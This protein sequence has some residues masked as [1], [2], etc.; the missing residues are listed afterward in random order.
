[1][2]YEIKFSDPAKPNSIVIEDGVINDQST[3]LNL[4]GKNAPS[5]GKGIAEN[6]VHSLENFASSAPPSNPIEGQLWFDTSNP[7]SKKLRINDGGVSG[8]RW[9]PINGVFQQSSQPTNVTVGDI[10]VDTNGNQLWIY[11]GISFTLVGPSYSSATLTGGY[12]T[13]INDRDGNSHNVIINYVNGEAIEVI[14][15]ETF[16][17]NDPAIDVNNFANGIYPGINVSTANKIS[18]VI[19]SAQNLQISGA[20]VAASQFLRKDVDQSMSARLNILADDSAL[21]IGVDPTIIVQRKSQYNANFVNTYPNEGVFTFD[22]INGGITKTIMYMS[23]ATNRVGINT[24]SPQ[25]ELD[26]TGSLR[27]SG[28]GTVSTLYVSSNATSALRVTGG[29]SIGGTVSISSATTISGLLTTNGIVPNGTYDIGAVGHA[30]NRVY[31]T[32]FYGA[33]RGNA[34][35]ATKWSTPTSFRS[36]ATSAEISWTPVSVDGSSPAAVFTPQAQPYIIFNRTPRNDTSATDTLMVYKTSPLDGVSSAA[37]SLVKE[38]KAAFLSDVNYHVPDLLAPSSFSTPYGSLVPPGT[39]VPYSGVAT[40]S[41]GIVEVYPGWL[42]C[43]GV[44]ITRSIYPTLCDTILHTYDGRT[45]GTLYQL[46]KLTNI[47]LSDTN[48]GVY[49]NYIIKY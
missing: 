12:P 23:N 21:K 49:I 39:I 31:A 6:F 22:F 1:M 8:A 9:T 35:T 5:Y 7:T 2:S 3:S 43:N 30:F 42:L 40:T 48:G 4:F 32:N 18:G 46:P 45:S 26:L 16:L 17:P 19:D 10:W 29:A 38:T 27:V 37:G 14:A 34:D 20:N 25:S 11:N 36:T 44:D 24:T 13:T 41:T 33:L 15:G 47:L 28:S